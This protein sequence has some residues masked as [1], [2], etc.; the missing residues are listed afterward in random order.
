MI[1]TKSKKV[2]SH[3]KRKERS[4][5]K[6][7]QKKRIQGKKEKLYLIIKTYSLVEMGKEGYLKVGRQR[8][9]K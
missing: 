5:R 2:K 7:K 6:K 4:E 1:C 9:R 3:G 8:A